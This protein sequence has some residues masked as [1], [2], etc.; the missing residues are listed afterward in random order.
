MCVRVRERER[1]KDR[2]PGRLQG[3][4]LTIFMSVQ[5]QHAVGVY[6]Q[7]LCESDDTQVCV[8]VSVRA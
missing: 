5:C 2:V 6:M 8:S 4:T 3:D 7:S 1:E